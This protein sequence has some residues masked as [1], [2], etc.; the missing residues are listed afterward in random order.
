M[1][2]AVAHEMP[3]FVSLSSMAP[4]MAVHDGGVHEVGQGGPG[5]VDAD[6]QP[7]HSGDETAEA[8]ELVYAKAMMLHDAFLLQDEQGKPLKNRPIRGRALC[9][10]P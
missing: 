5:Y 3:S 8:V 6:G 9:R 10:H 7:A 1:P 4:W 2:A